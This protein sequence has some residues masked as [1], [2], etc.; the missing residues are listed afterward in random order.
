[1]GVR[2]VLLTLLVCALFG[3]ATAH[4][5][6][7]Q[8]NITLIGDSVATGMQW[9]NDA[10]AVLQAG[11]DVDWEVAVCRR[12][13]APSCPFEGAVAPTL[14]DIV[15]K[16]GPKLAPVVVVEMGYNELEQT[17]ASSVETSINALLAGG[18]K[19]V[20][21]LNLRV[22]R[23]PYIPMNAMLVAAAKRHPEVA[24]V[25]WNKYSRSHPEWFQNDGEH[26][27][28]AGGVAMATLIHNAVQ[29]ALSPPVAVARHLASA[30][31]G[32]A[33][34]ARLSVRGG[35]TPVTWRIAAGHLPRGLELMAGGRIIGTPTQK[36]TAQVTLW[37][38][39]AYGMTAVCREVISVA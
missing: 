24:L 13:I 9:H 33:Y 36:G 17:F 11:L 14:V 29:D 38:T 16:L 23:H 34:S 37:A 21:W 22:S 10:I 6:S 19:R 4:A 30:R 1:M 8:P 12:L 32:R 18:A 39:D 25:D 15:Q 28:D 3:A 20:I 5:D 35:D 26:L 2:P 7:P 27:V 31:V